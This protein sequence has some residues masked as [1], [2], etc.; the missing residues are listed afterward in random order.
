MCVYE[1]LVPDWSETYQRGCILTLGE[2]GLEHCWQFHRCSNQQEP[3]V[4]IGVRDLGHVT[5]PLST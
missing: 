2:E 1:C 3:D 4:C 5:L